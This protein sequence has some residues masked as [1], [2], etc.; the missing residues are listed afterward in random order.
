[1]MPRKALILTLV[2]TTLASGC[3][4]GGDH[5]SNCPTS[6]SSGTCGRDAVISAGIGVAA[7]VVLAGGYYVVTQVRRSSSRSPASEQ[8]LVGQ[9]RWQGSDEG[10][11]GVLVTLRRPDG[12]VVPKATT[13]L[14]GWFQFPFPQKTDWYTLS[15]DTPSAMGETKVWLQNRRS[16]AIEVLVSRRSTTPAPDAGA[17]AD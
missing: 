5:Y 11:P 15:V 10:V 3:A 4:T 2:L 8:P 9:V 16:P 12:L 1:M 7:L 6:D 17:P 14:D 13:D